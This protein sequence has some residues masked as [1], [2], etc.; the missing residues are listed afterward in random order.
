[1]SLLYP[2]TVT[3]YNRLGGEGRAVSWQRTVL[4]EAARVFDPIGTVRAP[5]GDRPAAVATAVIA[6]AGY[7]APAAF[8]PGSAGWTL[9]PR[10]MVALGAQTSPE[11]PMGALTVS[12]AEAI[13]MGAS[14]DHVEAEF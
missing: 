1:M 14:V 13:R 11:P 10:D 6:P 5:G 12:V 4:T 8:A 7:T 2:D 3:V 9:R